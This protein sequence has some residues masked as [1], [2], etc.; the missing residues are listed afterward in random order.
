M[1]LLFLLL[2]TCLHTHTPGPRRMCG[3]QRSTLLLPFRQMELESNKQGL[4]G[5]AQVPA[6]HSHLQSP[7]LVIFALSV[8]STWQC[9]PG[10]A[11]GSLDC[12]LPAPLLLHLRSLWLASQCECW[13]FSCSLTSYS[14]ISSWSLYIVSWMFSAL[15]VVFLS[16]YLFMY[17]CCFCRTEARTQGLEH[18]RP[19]LWL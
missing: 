12:S 3:G 10:A 1:T 6:L 14:H 9:L 19:A 7:D 4:P 17:L 8:V 15:N 13:Y 18:A 11:P 5:L 2:C 16:Y